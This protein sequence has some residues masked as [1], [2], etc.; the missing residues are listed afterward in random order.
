MCRSVGRSVD[1][2]VSRR[3]G[4]HAREHAPVHRQSMRDLA[5]VVRMKA[6]RSGRIDRG[7]LGQQMM[8]RRR[9]GLCVR[10]MRIGAIVGQL[11]KQLIE[12]ER[13]QDRLDKVHRAAGKDRHSSA[14][15]HLGDRANRTIA[16]D[17]HVRRRPVHGRIVEAMVRDPFA[18]LRRRLVRCDRD[19]AVRLHRRRMRASATTGD[20]HGGSETRGPAGDDPMRR[21]VQQKRRHVRQR[22][23]TMPWRSKCGSTE[24]ATVRS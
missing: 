8:R 3:R 17:S 24:R 14:V 19:T 15:G 10:G 20:V 4:D 21:T 13:P 12:Q 5:R 23:A 18:L 11:R 2:S 7:Q 6:R 16:E 22:R 1:P 9:I